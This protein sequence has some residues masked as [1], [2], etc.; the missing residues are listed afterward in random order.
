MNNYKALIIDDEH[1]AQQG[2]KKVIQHALPDFFVS[3]DTASSVKEGVEK[4]KENKPDIV[5]LDIQMPEEF[6]FKLFDYFNDISFD[7]I[8]TT[9]H[10]DYI[11][12]AVNQWGCLGYLMKP[13]SISDLK[14]L[15]QR[16]EERQN[17]INRSNKIEIIKEDSEEEVDTENL[18]EIFKNE[19]GIIFIPSITEVLVLKINEIIY[20]KADDS[21]CTIYTKDDVFM[22]T[23]TLKEVEN[24]INQTNF[25]RVNRSYLVNINFAKKIDKRNNQLILNCSPKGGEINLPVT[26]LGYKILSNVVS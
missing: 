8:F 24:L 10:S 2:L 11:L 22:I 19:H 20:C 17:D 16:F 6:G 12:Q 5:F 26:S 7:V 1:F 25:F 3:I 4:I 14:I 21:Y 23:K 13:I 9:A 15:L 18:K